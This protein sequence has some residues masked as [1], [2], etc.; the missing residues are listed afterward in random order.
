MSQ[1]FGQGIFMMPMITFVSKQKDLGLAKDY[2]R[3]VVDDDAVAIP[4]NK[5]KARAMIEKSRTVIGLAQGM[6]NFSLSH[7][8]MKV[9]R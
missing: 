7:Q 1:D 8:G 2:A 9:L 3:A 4:K 6:T 5:E